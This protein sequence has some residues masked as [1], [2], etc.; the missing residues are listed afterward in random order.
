MAKTKNGRKIERERK[1]ANGGQ[2]WGGVKR[3]KNKTGARE[4]A[5]RERESGGKG[6]PEREKGRNERRG[7]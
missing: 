2:K 7:R 5:E 3:N 4:G 6:E 1:K